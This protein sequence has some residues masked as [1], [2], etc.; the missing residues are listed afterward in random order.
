MPQT[1]PAAGLVEELRVFSYGQKP[2]SGERTYSIAAT[3]NGVWDELLYQA[4]STTAGVV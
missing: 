3:M 1:I 2:G 4:G